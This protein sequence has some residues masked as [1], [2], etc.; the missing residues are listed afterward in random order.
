MHPACAVGC[1]NPELTLTHIHSVDLLANYLLCVVATT[2]GKLDFVAYKLNCAAPPHLVV[3]V[4]AA[5][6]VEPLQTSVQA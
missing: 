5:P 4:D 6:M 1:L 2:E 3:P